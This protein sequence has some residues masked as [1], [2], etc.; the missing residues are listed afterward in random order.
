[1]KRKTPDD[2]SDSVW[3]GPLQL[4]WQTALDVF[5]IILEKGYPCRTFV[6]IGPFSDAAKLIEPRVKTIIEGKELARKNIEAKYRKPF[7]KFE[8]FKFLSHGEK[9]YLSMTD[10]EFF[11]RGDLHIVSEDDTSA[12]ITYCSGG[13]ARVHLDGKGIQEI[14]R[15]LPMYDHRQGK[16]PQF[17]LDER[18]QYQHNGRSAANLKI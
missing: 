12:N 6:L 5:E 16:R 9:A 11:L 10:M 13:D 2:D 8:G 17:K 15:N 4:I 7:D 18:F 3:Q 1:M 14:A